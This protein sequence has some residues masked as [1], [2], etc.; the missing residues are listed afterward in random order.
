MSD[1]PL[2]VGRKSAVAVA[3]VGKKWSVVVE[4]AAVG[5][6]R[7]A[8]SAVD[9]VAVHADVADVVVAAAG[10]VSDDSAWIAAAYAVVGDVVV[11]VDAVVDDAAAGG[12]GAGWSSFASG[13]ADAIVAVPGAG[14]G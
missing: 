11:A 12:A 2:V 14:S 8:E 7:R 10:I 6:D 9:A 13:P 3:V 4:F 5:D 1:L